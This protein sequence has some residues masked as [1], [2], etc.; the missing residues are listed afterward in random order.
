MSRWGGGG[1]GGEGGRREGSL[2]V[3]DTVLN[4]KPQY[5]RLFKVTRVHT[6]Q[7]LK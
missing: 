1:G 3:S 7:C 2:L 4:L 6:G 5:V